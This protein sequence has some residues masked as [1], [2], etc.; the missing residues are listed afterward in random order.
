MLNQRCFVG[1]TVKGLKQSCFVVGT[2]KVLNQSCFVGGTV[3]DLNQSCFVGRAFTAQT[4]D[5]CLKSRS[6]VFVLVYK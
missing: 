5:F 2:V 3:K 6:F 4:R 1:G